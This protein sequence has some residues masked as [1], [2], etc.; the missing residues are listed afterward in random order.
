M[1]SRLTIIEEASCKKRLSKPVFSRVF[2]VVGPYAMNERWEE[3]NELP[4]NCLLLET[5]LTGICHADLRYVSASRPPEILRERLPM[6]VFH[7][8]TAKVVDFGTNV[9]NFLKGD[10][11][12][13]V[14]NIPCYI[15]NPKKYP[16][17]YRACKACRPQ[18]AGENLCED[19]RFLA[20]NAQG[21]SRTLFVHPAACVF[22]LPKNVP[23][24]IAVL[25]EPLTVINRAIKQAEVNFNGRV[26]VLGSGFMGFITAAVLSKII[27]ISKDNL[28]VTDI[29]DFK[30]EKVKDLAT[31]FNTKDKPISKELASSFDVAFECVGGKA[32]EITIEQA[33]FL[34]SPGGKCILIGVSE[35]KIPIKT[36]DILEKG[37]TIKG[38]TRSAA[39]DYPET[40]EWL[41]REEFK[42]VLRRI[43]YPKMF[44][45][46]DGESII[47]ACKTAEN[48][49][50]HG[51]VLIDWRKRTEN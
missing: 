32:S 21:L 35:E 29:M 10:L 11:V 50:T 1:V 3:I 6:C 18:G 25:T 24:E 27:G 28:L 19:V 44:T 15:H 12:V 37:L 41:K 17:N 47:S 30:L 8:G 22:P 46:K 4:D 42:E 39:V 20:S 36:R 7:E 14:P 33:S 51:K 49:E 43:I 13:V 45:P 16:D 9:Q 2:E 40:L 5:R 26:A 38:T 31:V 48:P 34:L 23:E